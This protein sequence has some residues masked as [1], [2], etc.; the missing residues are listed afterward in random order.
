MLPPPRSLELLDHVPNGCLMVTDDGTILFWNAVL[1]SWTGRSRAEVCGHRLYDLFPSLGAPR[2]RSR[3]DQTLSLGAP[4]VFSALL[5]LPLFPRVRKDGRRRYEQVTITR[6][7]A[8]SDERR[9]ALI[10]ISDVTE[11]Y[12][13]GERFR[14]ESARATAESAIRRAQAAELAVA[15]EAA[16]AATLAKSVFL[17]AMSHELRTPMNGVLGM[18]DMLLHS[19]LTAWQREHLEILQ[20]SASSLLTVLNDILDFSKI[21]ANKLEIESIPFEPRRVVEECIVLVADLAHAKSLE[22]TAIIST[23]V[24][25]TLVGDPVRFRQV[26]MNLLSNAVKF[27]KHGEI[28]VQLG[29]SGK[30]DGQ[31]L[32][33]DVRDTGDGIPPDTCRRLFEPFSQA[34]ASTS[35]LHGGTGLGLSICRRLLHLMDGDIVIESEVGR[36]SVFRFHLRAVASAQE[37]QEAEA[38]AAARKL[39]VAIA[40]THEASASSLLTQMASIGVEARLVAPEGLGLADFRERLTH[41]VVDSSTLARCTK[42]LAAS[43]GVKIVLAARPAASRGAPPVGVHSLLAMPSRATSLE[44]AIGLGH[45]RAPEEVVDAA[46]LPRRVLVAEDDRTNQIVVRAMLTRLGCS[47]EVVADGLA[48]VEAATRGTYDLVLMDVQMPVLG[49]CEAT[50]RLRREGYA[51]PILALTASVLAEEQNACVAAGMNEVL[52]KPINAGSLRAALAR[53]RGDAEYRS[54]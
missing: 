10:T 54:A 30:G 23:E 31:R 1:E 53:W 40:L 47:V 45:V 24:P 13:R 8:R 33:C 28:V 25:R 22:C 36:G 5:T 34:A 16:E 4:S 44:H 18:A 37:P 2:F 14:E 52:T 21:E 32:W 43:G 12:E 50:A 3:V 39:F 46:R 35:R 49:G 6:T 9:E 20:A 29:A 26:L 48:A 42:E 15:K 38:A 41:V 7:S 17:A 27:T 51:G 19:D 11:Q